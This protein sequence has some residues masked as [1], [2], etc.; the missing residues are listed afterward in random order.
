M[1]SCSLAEIA[2][3]FGIKL[4]RKIGESTLTLGGAVSIDGVT[5]KFQGRIFFDFTVQTLA[6]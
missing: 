5:S 4:S 2:K 3:K 6:F 1:V